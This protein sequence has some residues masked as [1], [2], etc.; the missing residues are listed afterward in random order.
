M[1]PESIKI[2]GI[3]DT[4]ICRRVRRDRF[5]LA[6][7]LAL[8]IF[9]L[10]A[11]SCFAQSGSTLGS[12]EQKLFFKSYGDETDDARL[13]RLEKHLFGQQM[14]GAFQERLNRV[15]GAASPQTNPD[16]SVSGMSSQQSS[17]TTNS[18]KPPTEAEL[19]ERA[20]DDRQAAMER[21]KIAVAAAR[22]EQTNKLIES[23]VSLWRAKRGT[24]ALQYFEQALK[25]DPHNANALYYAGI[26]YE[27][28]KSY[29]EALSSYRKASN[30]DPGNQEYNEAVVAVQK[31]MNSRP[32]IDPKQ[33]EISKL[34]TEAG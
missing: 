32:A 26:V 3:N 7:L 6:G 11:P 17:S 31:L 22:D 12:L 5:K 34:A 33:A 28:K 27:S 9:L 29:I 13:A 23:G 4:A 15:M 30:E 2:S 21:A 24:E 10:N 8:S 19:K 20:E 16:G 14:E 1:G 18:V 25:A